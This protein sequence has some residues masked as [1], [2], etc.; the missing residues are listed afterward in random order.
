MN[1]TVPLF[2]P[3]TLRSVSVKAVN[4]DKAT[5]AEMVS[6]SKEGSIAVG[7]NDKGKCLVATSDILPGEYI[8]RY[9]GQLLSDQEGRR[10]FADYPKNL[11]SYMIHFNPGGGWR[12]LDATVSHLDKPGRYINHSLNPNLKAFSIKI[13]NE[14]SVYFTKKFRKGRNCCGFIMNG[15]LRL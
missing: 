3:Y 7:K 4:L 14:W 11:G 8:C 12:W 10:R 9:E 13:K 5:I 2:Q 15:I 6:S 1:L